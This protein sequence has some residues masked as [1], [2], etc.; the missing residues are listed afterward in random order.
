MITAGT[1]LITLREI[2]YKAARYANRT[3]SCR[4]RRAKCASKLSE[5]TSL[6]SARFRVSSGSNHILYVRVFLAA[7]LVASELVLAN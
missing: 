7:R 6:L 4:K 5:R 3:T 1:I 2:Q